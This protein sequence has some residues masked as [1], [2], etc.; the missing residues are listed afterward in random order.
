MHYL[1]LA[2][3]ILCEVIGTTFMKESQGFKKLIPSLVTVVSYATA[4]YFLSI[5]LKTIPTGVAYAIWSGVGIVLIATVGWAFQGQ[6]LDFAAML[7]MGLIVAGVAVIQ[8]FSN[9]TPH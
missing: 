2:L 8:L 6:R 7:G 4:F 3:A 1:P 9:T 5:T